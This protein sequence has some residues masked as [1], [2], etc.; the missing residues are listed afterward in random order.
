M[1]SSF[2]PVYAGR[3][4]DALVRNR[5]LYQVQ[6][7]QATL[8]RLQT[9]L[10]TGH[11]F[12][13]VSEAP[14]A[15]IRVI[16]L[17][18][19]QEFK[20][21]TLVNLKSAQGYLNVTETS[22]AGVQDILNEIKGIT[23]E[24][25]SNVISEADRQGFKSQLDAYL[26]RLVSISNQHSQDRYLFTGGEVSQEPVELRNSV[27]RFH[28][29]DLDLLAIGDQNSYI[30]HNV[31]GQRALGLISTG[32]T[33]SVDL[34]PSLTPDTRL[35]DLNNGQGI[36]PGAIEFSNGTASVVVDLASAESIQDVLDGIN[37][38]SVDGRSVQATLS[39]NGLVINY[40]DALPG[41]L[42][43]RDS[44]SGRAAKNLGIATNV[45]SPP[46]PNLGS[47][48]NPIIR[49]TTLLSQLNNGVGLNTAGGFR[50][51]Q[52]E[53]SYTVDLTGATTVDDA[54]I[55]I[56]NSGAA[57]IADIAPGG[58]SLR[59]RSTESGSDFS[60]A[61]STGSLATELGLRTFHGQVPLSSLNHGLGLELTNG[62]DLTFTRSDGTEFSVDLSSA[63]TV[64]DVID[65][66]NNSPDNQ[67][68]NLRIVIAAE[69]FNRGLTLRATVPPTPALPA[70]PPVPISVRS[71]GGSSAAI[72]LGLT[73]SGTATATI[74]GTEYVLDGRNPNPQETQGIFN[75]IIRL[76][77][78]IEKGDIGAT[79]RAAQLLEKDLER[80]SLTR[81]D[82][83]I[84]QQRIDYLKS[85]SEDSI[86][87]LKSQ[88][89][90]ARDADIANVISELTA[91]QAA[92]ESNIKLLAQNVR[93]TIFDFI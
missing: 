38:V 90:D 34:S 58:R 67:D 15:A 28:G 8:Q 19:A 44:G 9:A 79:T 89:S 77:E 5:S 83:G 49:N 11:R 26:S 56:N 59:I 54:L 46:L 74:I 41:T 32:V 39:T 3:V 37:S 70:L 66:V 80:V 50:I 86:H 92:Y 17:Q 45:A 82:L 16:G 27:V 73:Q 22:L 43:I 24:A 93:R 33:G 53:Q 6:S 23:V 21:Q 78:A 35:S 64:Q 60:I 47:D 48:L 7:D 69:P 87:E 61:E 76:R 51:F 42:R 29:D 84:R 1:I 2:Y 85:T 12:Q 88:E 40:A 36:N 57:V 55:A 71:A 25:A 52:G 62:P 20:E 91:R 10:T 4:S 63:V 14:S 72:G 18:R 65:T 30:S 31:T 75:T 68:P 13:S 81:G